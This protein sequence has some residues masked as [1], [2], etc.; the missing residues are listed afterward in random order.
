MCRSWQRYSFTYIPITDIYFSPRCNW[1]SHCQ[2]FIS[3][4]PFLKCIDMCFTETLDLFMCCTFVSLLQYFRF[5]TISKVWF[6]SKGVMLLPLKIENLQFS[7]YAKS[8][9]CLWYSFWEESSFAWGF[10]I[11]GIHGSHQVCYQVWLAVSLLADVIASST[12]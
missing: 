8:G 4:C 6:I 9:Q 10:D 2:H 7:G 3:A 11:G 12:Q 5:I 1:I